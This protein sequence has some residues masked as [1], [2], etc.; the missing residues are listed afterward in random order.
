VWSRFW[1]AGQEIFNTDQ[2][3][4]FTSKEFTNV[5]LDKGI[6]ISMDGQGRALDNVFVERLWWTVKYEDVYPKGY[7]YGIE[8][9][10]GLGKYFKY[11][12]KKRGHSSLDKR[13]PAEVFR[14]G[15]RL[16]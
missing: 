15:A 4:Q 16:H 7:A 11:Y 8:L 3:A 14:K 1:E 5:L 6:T 9:H 12:N 2:G 13:T 10:K